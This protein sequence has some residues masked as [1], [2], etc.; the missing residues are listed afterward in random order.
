MGKSIGSASRW[1]RIQN[2]TK[3]LLMPDVYTIYYKTY[4]TTDWG[5]ATPT[6]TAQTYN[7]ST[8]IPC[9]LQPYR[10][11]REKEIVGMD[12]NLNYY[13]LF[14]P[15]DAPLNYDS[16]IVIDGI[17]YETFRIIDNGDWREAKSAIVY[18]L[19][20]PDHD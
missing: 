19:R 10:G 7:S 11:Y 12:T 5:T 16:R 1:Q 18:E 20:R 3:R 6:E 17:S 4:T 15:M 13:E 14:V 8:S 9:R 2:Q